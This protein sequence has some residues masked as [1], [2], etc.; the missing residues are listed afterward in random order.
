[1]IEPFLYEQLCADVLLVFKRMSG[2][3]R[4]A[5]TLGGSHGK[6]LSDRSS[7]FDFRVYFDEPADGPSWD[8]AMAELNGLMEKWKALDVEIDGG[9]P[10]NVAEIDHQ[11]DEWLG[12]DTP[13]G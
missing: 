2:G 5:I 13:H 12:A 7:D 1:M 3:E 8:L 11:L 4:Y 10:R 9:W 6:G